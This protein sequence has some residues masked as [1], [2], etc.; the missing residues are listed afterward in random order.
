MTTETLDKPPF[1]LP[2]G[3]SWPRNTG[4]LMDLVGRTPLYRIRKLAPAHKPNVE[5][6]AKLEMKN[7]GGSVKDRAAT[8]M[9][10]RGLQTGALKPG[11]TILDSTSGNTGIAL[12][13]LGAALGFPVKLCIP[14]SASAER[15]KV[16]RSF[17]AE[18]VLT[19]PLEGSDG[20]I[21]RSREIHAEDPDRYF[22]PDQYNNL[23]NVWAHYLTT[24][25]EILEQTDGRVTHFLAT[26]GTSGTVMGTG[27]GLRTRKPGTQIIAVEPDNPF[28]GI[29][30]LKHIASSIVPGIYRD[31]GFDRVMP[32]E[33]EPAYNMVRA[34]ARE[35]GLLIGP[36]AGAALA[37]ALKVAEEI[38][39]GVL[40]CIFCD[41][42][43]RYFSTQVFR[44]L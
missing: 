6:Y 21:I 11:K 23:A 42:G 37:A 36:S 32:A 40:V 17:G 26:I 14:A 7:P 33:T 38:D 12:A 24:A 3:V 1:A 44:D 27:W 5:I 34:V 39:E 8:M 31:N 29:E 30:G 25:P 2:D 20:A 16:L 18:L 10:W 4:T 15:L 28:H 9:I 41:S 43:E 13:M 22:K 19:D 35:E